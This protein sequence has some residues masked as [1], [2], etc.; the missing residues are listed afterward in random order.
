M[1]GD[2]FDPQSEFFTEE[3]CLPHWSQAGSV[4]FITFRTNDSIP[5]EVIER[6]D[7]EKED[8]LGRRGIA[9]KQPWFRVL[10]SLS[11][12]DRADFQRTFHRAREEFLDTCHGRC[13]LKRPELA[14]IVANSLLHFDGAR[15]R[16]GEFVI[17]P[18]HVHLLAVFPTA[19]AMK[20]QCDSWLHYTAFQINQAIGE[21]GKLWQQEPFD[22]LVRSVQQYE[23]LRKYIADNPSKAGLGPEAYLYRRFDG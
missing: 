13:L 9:T 16:M 17:M 15:Y 12:Q 2:C 23:D 22:H 6:W 7:R 11:K 19:E 10:P 20:V 3:H 14:R 8:W 1:L 21:K 5:R 4:V 18:N